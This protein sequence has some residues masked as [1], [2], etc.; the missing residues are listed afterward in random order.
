MKG[1]QYTMRSKVWLYP[2]PPAGGGAWHFVNVDKKKSREIKK[3]Y[4]MGRR[5]FGSVPVSVTIGKTSWRTSIFPDKKSGTYVLPL[6]AE[7]RKKEGIGRDD[8]IKFSIEIQ[9]STIKI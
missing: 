2:G 4:G 9:P 1:K 6:K 8:T 5:G 3:K 7:V